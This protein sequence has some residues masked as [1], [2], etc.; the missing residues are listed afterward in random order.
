[1]TV[2]LVANVTVRNAENMEAYAAAAGPTLVAHGGELVLDGQHAETLSGRW[3]TPGVALVRFPDV[4]AARKWY[5]SPEYQALAPLRSSAADMDI[6][7]F[8]SA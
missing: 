3:D 8:T 1:M 6:A 7:L 5:N 4:E 2:Y